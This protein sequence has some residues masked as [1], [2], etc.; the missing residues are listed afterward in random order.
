MDIMPDK[1]HSARDPRRSATQARTGHEL[2]SG[3]IGRLFVRVL[4]NP[5]RGPRDG[6]GNTR[7]SAS[8]KRCRTTEGKTR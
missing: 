6:T 3:R 4:R 1:K 8:S 7:C 5:L 2:A